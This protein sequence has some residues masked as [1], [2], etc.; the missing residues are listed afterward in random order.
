LPGGERELRVHDG[1]TEISLPW[2]PDDTV[3]DL[4]IR[5]ADEFGVP[6]EVDLV[7]SGK[8]LA[9]DDTIAEAGLDRNSYIYTY[10]KPVMDLGSGKGTA[11]EFTVVGNQTMQS[12]PFAEE[13]TVKDAKCELGKKLYK[14]FGELSI[15]DQVGG[16]CLDDTQRLAEV[17]KPGRPF[18]LHFVDMDFELNDGQRR[19]IARWMPGRDIE[20]EGKELFLR[21]GGSSTIFPRTCK[22]RGYV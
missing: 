6:S 8:I 13:K 7:A 2:L 5:L 21:C 11:F 12:L 20:T 16:L 14:P 3:A 22:R 4:K 10:A 17:M 9:D 1:R 15:V 18:A 19:L